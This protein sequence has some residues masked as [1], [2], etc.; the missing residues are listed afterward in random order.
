VTADAGEARPSGSVPPETV[1]REG[2]QQDATPASWRA[3]AFGLLAGGFVVG[4]R[5]AAGRGVTR[6]LVVGGVAAALGAVVPIA[7][8]SRRPDPVTAGGDA[9]DRPVAADD[10]PVT[11]TFSVIVPAR[12]E[13]EVLPRLVRDLA[14]QDHRTADGRPLFEVILVD[15]RSVDGTAQAALRAAAAGGL[16]DVTRIIRRGGDDLPDGKGAALTAAQPEICRGDVVVVLDADA[17]VGPAFLSTLAGYFDAGFEAVTPRRRILDADS[18]WL[19]GAQADEQT[20]DGEIQRGRWLLGGCSEFRGN[21]IAVRRAL[22]ADVGGWR[23]EALTEDLDLSSRIAARHGT[24]VAWAIEAE[25][26]EEPVR[27]WDALWR[28]RVRWAEGGVRRL[29]EHGPDVFQSGRL[30]DRARLDFAA[31]AVQLAVPPIILGALVRSWRS[32]RG[33]MARLLLGAYGLATVALGFDALRWEADSGGAPLLVT[34]RLR[35]AVR[36]AAFGIVWIAAVPAALWRLA[37]RE[38]AV[39]YDKMSH[40]Q[41]R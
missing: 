4:Y 10:P 5:A 36:L 37:M 23:A 2:S 1:M 8:A 24:T 26:W 9:D 35:R 31:Y 41:P 12:D 11:T 25:V 15:D 34:E 39:T 3:A 14:A 21:G 22:L 40:G 28:Q 19:A 29:L 38:G 30:S 33:G 13:V 17:H 7:L 32:G 27:R 20:V 16:S 18:S 6:L